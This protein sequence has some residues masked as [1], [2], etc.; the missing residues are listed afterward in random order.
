MQHGA[1]LRTGARADR[2]AQRDAALVARGASSDD[3]RLHA[4]DLPDAQS[5]VTAA[6][7]MAGAAQERSDSD[8]QEGGGGAWRGVGV[9]VSGLQAKRPLCSWRITKLAKHRRGKS[10]DGMGAGGRRGTLSSMRSS[11]R[12]R[13]GS[14]NGRKCTEAT[15]SA[16]GTRRRRVLVKQL[17]EERCE[18]RHAA[19]ECHEDAEEHLDGGLRVGDARAALETLAVHLDVPVGQVLDEAQQPR[20]HL[21]AGS[22][23]GV[24]VSSQGG[25]PDAS[26]IGKTT[27]LRRDAAWVRLVRGEGR[28]VST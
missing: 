20:H 5:A 24:R 25:G 8:A 12:E 4:A 22:G 2:R 15:R 19:H 17:A 18:G 14:G 3:K 13:S 1:G 10:A 21:P 16:S 23:L 28:G 11:M 9:G 27:G 6:A 26:T 7:W